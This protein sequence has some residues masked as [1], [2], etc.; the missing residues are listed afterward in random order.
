MV[1]RKSEIM[2]FTGSNQSTN[3]SS[4][5]LGR[6][7]KGGCPWSA[8]RFCS[9]GGSRRLNLT[10][11]SV[12][13]IIWR[14]LP[15]I[16]LLAV[17]QEMHNCAGLLVQK[18]SAVLDSTVL[19]CAAYG[20]MGYDYAMLLVVLVALFAVFLSLS[21][22]Q[23]QSKSQQSFQTAQEEMFVRRSVLMCLC[24]ARRL[25]PS[26]HHVPSSPD[27]YFFLGCLKRLLRFAVWL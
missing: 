17:V 11:V 7:V 24:R 21:R 4:Q 25:S 18:P 13:D 12:P 27:K 16:P 19:L 2:C 20:C 23:P 26:Q 15:T 8:A 10:T 1:I 3:S 14:V 6:S 5:H 22:S 9:T